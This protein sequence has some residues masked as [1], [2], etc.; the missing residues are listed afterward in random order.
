L[1]AKLSTPTHIHALHVWYNLGMNKCKY[2]EIYLKEGQ[3]C[4]TRENILKLLK[5]KCVI[6]KHYIDTGDIEV[7]IKNHAMRG[8]WC[9]HCNA[10]AKNKTFIQK[11]WQQKTGNHY[12]YKQRYVLVVLRNTFQ[13]LSQR[14]NVFFVWRL[15]CVWSN[16]II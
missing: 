5:D 12:Q 6:C 10:D 3:E 2:C 11:I 9:V 13:H 4:C 8:N 7:N 14:I 16:G 15:I 1:L